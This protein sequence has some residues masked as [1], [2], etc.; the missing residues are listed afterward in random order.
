MDI[1]TIRI[2]EK[3]NIS[4]KI[5][6]LKLLIKRNDETVERLKTINENIEFNKKQIEKI[7]EKNNEY[8]KNLIELEKNLID[9]INGACD[10]TIISEMNLT[11]SK[12]IKNYTEKSI[13][14]KIIKKE[15]KEKQ[16][17]NLKKSYNINNSYVKGEVSERDID[18]AFQKYAKDE[19]SIPDYIKNNLKEMPCNK[20]YIWKGIYCY[21]QLRKEIG[22]PQ[23]MFEKQN[24][25]LK[26]LEVYDKGD[27]RIYKRYEKQGKNRK[28]FVSEEAVNKIIFRKIC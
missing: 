23:I 3:N 12:I 7:Y 2:R 28:I 27:H 14:N 26:I 19:A 11:N 24:G 22:E 9:V 18:R 13:K 17:T 8:T 25:I 4:L 21:G 6:S 10:D 5:N 15:Q 1:N 16:D 20:G